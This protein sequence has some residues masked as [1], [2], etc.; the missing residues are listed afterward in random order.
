MPLASNA[1]KSGATK[2]PLANVSP[3]PSTAL[4]QQLRWQS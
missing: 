1:N 2:A 3:L 4:G